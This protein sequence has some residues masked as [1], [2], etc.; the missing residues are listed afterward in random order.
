VARPRPAVVGLGI[1]AVAAAAAIIVRSALVR[2]DTIVSAP[3]TWQGGTWCPTYRAAN[4]CNEVQQSGSNSSVPFY[5]A[6]VTRRVNPDSILLKMNA[7]A[8][9][10]GAFNTQ[11]HETFSAPATISE[12]LSL[13]C[14][15][16]G[17]IEN[18]PAFWLVTTGSWPAGGEI[19]VMEGLHGYAAW[20]YH[21][22]N[23]SG[24][25]SQAGGAVSG[26]SGC[27]THTYRVRWTTS[28]ITFYYDGTKV[29]QVTPAEIGVPLATGPMYVIND[30]AAS[31]TY[32]GPTTGD[33][34]MHV[35]S[36]TP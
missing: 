26:F 7:E 18:W 14:D 15:I 1:A 21:Y 32:G 17:Q 8:T 29:G 19:D 27:G 6:Q 34:D 31:P 33:V 12:Q 16:G 28:A 36:F 11:T 2:V 3:F 23:S 4:G 22:L 30:Y 13:P 25:R 35:L 5:P 24:V 20:H 9:E 10:T